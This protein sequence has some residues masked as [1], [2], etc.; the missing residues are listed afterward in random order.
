M[1]RITAY[2]LIAALAGSGGIS[3]AM[4]AGYV[5]GQSALMNSACVPFVANEGQVAN[6]D[7]KYY[8]RTFGGTIYALADGRIVYSLPKYD[9]VAK[10]GP[11][12]FAGSAVFTERLCNGTVF[13]P[14][15]ADK[16]RVAVSS[17]IGSRPENWKSNL[18]AF[19]RLD[20]G[21][22]YEGINLLLRVQGNNVEKVF[23]VAPHAD[24]GEI[25]LRY[26]GALG[27]EV[28]AS[29][30]LE[31][32]SALGQIYFT[33]PVAWQ[34]DES[35][36][37]TS[38]IQHPT[39]NV[40]SFR[41][42]HTPVE[43]AYAVDEDGSVRFELGAYDRN[44]VLIIDPLLAST[45]IG[46]GGA[47]AAQAIAVDSQTNVF[48]A[49]Y[50]YSADFPVTNNQY[51]AQGQY[52]V[53]VSK[54]DANLGS[55]SASTYIGGASNDLATAIGIDAGS[56]IWLVGYTQ[57]T[58]FPAQGLNPFDFPLSSTN[59]GGEDAFVVNL[60]NNLQL[61]QATYL[62]GSN[63]DRATAI[64]IGDFGHCVVGYTESGNFPVTNNSNYAVTYNGNRD[65]F[66]S[67]FTD[68][69]ICRVNYRGMFLGGTNS[70][71]ANGVTLRYGWGSTNSA[72]IAGS[73]TSTNFPITNAFCSNLCGEADAFICRASV[74]MTNLFASTFLG[75][76]ADDKAY[77]IGLDLSNKVYVA[78]W[79]ASADFP[80]TN[81]PYSGALA[82][83]QDVFVSCLTSGV[84]KLYASTYI[85]GAGNDAAKA[86]M[87]DSNTN[88]IYVYLAGSTYSADFPVS[89]AA[90]DRSYN[91]GGD[92]FIQRIYGR[93]T[94]ISASTYLGGAGS[95]QAL[96]MALAPD[97]NTV[98]VA[99]ITASSD[100]PASDAAY[101]T[102]FCGGASDG[103]A[104][105]FPASLAYGTEKWRK[106]LFG[107][108]S[109]PA[110]TW[111]GTV[112]IGNATSLY[113]YSSSGAE[114]W[115]APTTSA[116]ARQSSPGEGY[117]A[118]AVGT[119]NIIYINTG[120]GK[121][122]AV[123]PTTGARSLLFSS[124]GGPAY[125][126][127]PAFDN[128]G[129]LYFISQ[130]LNFYSV[131]MD[132]V[133]HWTNTLA[134]NGKSSPA[135]GADGAIYAVASDATGGG[136]K[137]YKFNAGGATNA[138]WTTPPYMFSS[139][140][141]TETNIYMPAGSN[142]YIFNSD[143]SILIAWTNANKTQIWSSPA[144]G[145]NGDIY[146]GGGSNLYAYNPAS[147]APVKAWCAG[148]EIKSSPAIASDGS[149]IVGAT[150]G[151]YSFN[152][153]GTTNW[154]FQTYADIQ[155]QSPLIDGDGMIY[156]SDRAYFYALYGSAPPADSAWPMYRRDGLRTANQGFDVSYFLRP[157]GLTVAKGEYTNLVR[158]AWSAVSNAL[159]Y[160]LWRNV[161][162]A[163]N[164]AT[165]VKRLNRTTY[166]DL[167][168][169]PGKIYYYWVKA[170][171][172]LA[173]SSFS[174]PD[175]GG[176]PPNP[177]ANVSA[178]DGIPT[179]YIH[180]TWQTSVNATV[181]YVYRS[182][183]DAT[184]TAVQVTS[185]G[186]TNYNDY[187][188]APG[189]T[190]YYWVKAGNDV[191]GISLF[192]SSASGGIPPSPP[193]GLSATQGAA[194][195][196]VSLSWNSTVGADLYLVY[197]NT[198]NNAGT[199]G[200]IAG[201]TDLSLND[202]DITSLCHY[203]Y[204]VR[205]TNSA[206]GV[207]GF[208]D[209]AEGWGLLAAP[210]SVRA[211]TGS[212]SNY[213]RVSWVAGSADATAHVIY[214]G[215]NSSSA[216]ATW[217][218]EVIYNPSTATN[219]D[220]T[221]ISR[222]ISYY[223]WVVARNDYGSSTWTA[224]DS[225]GGTPPSAPTDV[226][227][228]DGVSTTVIDV[229]WV[230]SVG[231]SSYIIYRGETFNSASATAI[232]VSSSNYYSDYTAANGVLYYYWVMAV[233]N[234]Y[235]SSSMSAFNSGWRALVPPASV[236]ASDGITTNDLVVIWSIAPNATVYELWRGTSGDLACASRLA[237]NIA[238][239]SYNDV[240]SVAGTMYYY[241]V[242]SKRSSFVSD[243]S[244]SD[245]GFK[246][247]GYIDLSA[248]DF[249][250]LPATFKPLAHPAAVSFRVANNSVNDMIAPN[251]M[252]RYD[253]YL[254][255]NPDFSGGNSC[256]IGGSNTSLEL[257]AGKSACVISPASAKSAIAIPDWAA[258][259]YYVFVFIN[260]CLPSM[261]L[262]PDLSNNDARRAGDAIR[263]GAATAFQP[264][265]N[266]YDG[267]GKTDLAVYS[268]K[269]GAW[270]IWLSTADWTPEDL[271]GPGGPGQRPVPGDYDGDGKFDPAAYAEAD[272][273]WT[274]CCSATGERLAVT[275]LGGSGQYAVPADYDGDGKVDPAVYQETTGK[276]RVWMS[277]AGYAEASAAGLGGAGWR[278]AAADYDG[279][280]K[281]DPAVY[282]ENIG[283]WHFWLSSCS[284]VQYN[285]SGW[286]APGYH[287]ASADYDGDSKIDP[288]V[289]NEITG[290]WSVWVSGNAYRASGG[291]GWGGAG[292]AAVPGDYDGDG[293]VD[294]VV[295]WASM[296]IWRLWLSTLSY[297]ELNALASSGEGFS[298]VT[299]GE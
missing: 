37:E 42:G 33:R 164:T 200:I 158:V 271:S 75:G 155:L 193:A 79:T 91:G 230:A 56:T 292:Q 294:P 153:N 161:T 226:T 260:H 141:L 209:P 10:P 15:G 280:L 215:T 90:Y 51:A 54:F 23:V 241:W 245:S 107:V 229:Q 152:P 182:L 221:A 64:A 41:H 232:G 134:S 47:D 243:F 83:G 219:Y 267:D 17:F 71:E 30:E 239:N 169:E 59:S 266:D 186:D 80:T 284:Y 150:D 248:S 188:V 242:K 225:P 73:T 228:G 249:V 212:F 168:V 171:T 45:F 116:V 43:V 85:G 21:E 293:K 9:A 195:R 295:Y 167:S 74:L 216:A 148:G 110:L 24:P 282:N 160:E 27:V 184:G 16:S 289:Y 119:N 165:L 7:V 192:S 217:Q 125:W 113:A 35:A 159:N 117:G 147:A 181:Y 13:E 92:A 203:Y 187:S 156:V 283:S 72:Y 246:A 174:D 70:D 196:L 291:S 84:A 218:T 206:Y 220:D 128:Y 40:E 144:I 105:K 214:R 172:P 29:G 77:A 87:V 38:N 95:D 65:A 145:T 233:N 234:Y 176:I 269:A 265:W 48:V 44:K 50:T 133:S 227:A 149:I 163:S 120:S 22:V 53:F 285:A 281:A 130:N 109:T 287:A 101:E 288:A 63:D 211:T 55:L 244:G 199:A 237:N 272:G 104:S 252:M 142:L 28:A 39:L 146:V 52:D 204:W 277:G 18:P 123:N 262:D 154:F 2:I 179:N 76:A 89:S 256:W 297:C 157:A 240:S 276:W 201:T 57:S 268:E 49:G 32:Q 121:A 108:C 143:G 139:P 235:G 238:T 255:D 132:G 210:A 270:R 264:V 273:G 224:A 296:G 175:F 4:T 253:V 124:G 183:S 223:Y 14:L 140:A 180:V 250:F 46:G 103:F 11:R 191:A 166:N 19:D 213:I 258:G 178:S 6:P 93:L 25:S 231:A 69:A 197:R 1:R 88:R 259:S 286:G 26:E 126:S 261:W 222:G 81:S 78:G 94:N 111:D 254:S 207:S 202:S 3:S 31:L 205:A 12:A 136:P 236:S 170:R 198:E 299:A 138:G 298:A 106:Y 61:R 20:F 135:I 131:G 60:A 58:N 34:I 99:G 66:A 194:I 251:S 114:R 100:F 278:P 137:I 173:K 151:V 112:L 127:A 102:V 208:G 263:I 98:F 118:P 36:L 8:A 275:M 257:K 122:Y 190:H 82:G 86:L 68:S 162:A 97:S 189:V 129:R 62:G 5:Q 96:G 177:P 274:V 185:T 67:I 115:Q 279:D 247:L 290:S